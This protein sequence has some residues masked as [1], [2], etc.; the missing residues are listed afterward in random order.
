MVSEYPVVAKLVGGKGGMGIFG[1]IGVAFVVLL[2][3]FGAVDF[4]TRG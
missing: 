3:A 4:M 1:D 2:F